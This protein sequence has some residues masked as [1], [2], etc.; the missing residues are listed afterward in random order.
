MEN[1]ELINSLIQ[2][3]DELADGLKLLSE[4]QN[5][6]YT[7]VMMQL[8][9]M[10][11]TG[12]FGD[13]LTEEELYKLAKE[14]VIKSNKASASYLQRVFKIGYARAARII[15]LLEENGI[16]GPGEGATPRKVFKTE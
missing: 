7:D 15:D 2:K 8:K 10:V 1:K 12:D 13:D 16:I 5:S 9:E 14:T 11:Q 6:Q 4:R 3:I